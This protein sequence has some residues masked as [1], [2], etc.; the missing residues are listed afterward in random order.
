MAKLTTKPGSRKRRQNTAVAA[1]SLRRSV[2]IAH[3]TVFRFND[4]PLELRNAV[5]TLVL[6]SDVELTL[7]NQLSTLAKALNQVSRTVRAESLSIY[8]SVNSF[9]ASVTYWSNFSDP[10][11]A[12]QELSR[13][14]RWFAL[15]GKLAARH[16]RT[17]SITHTSIYTRGRRTC[18]AS[19]PS[20]EWVLSHSDTFFEELRASFLARLVRQSNDSYWACDSEDHDAGGVHPVGV[21]RAFGELRLKPEALRMLLRGLQLVAPSDWLSDPS[22]VSATLLSQLA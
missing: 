3:R 19:D 9:N 1:T 20:D 7:T 6:E 14:E 21:L 10:S 5:Y 17:L 18:L 8:Y 12:R 15:F 16:I 13:I 11:V 4:L 2:R 22:V